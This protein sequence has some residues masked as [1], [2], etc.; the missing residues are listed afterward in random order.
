MVEFEESA[1][2]SSL[3]N[4]LNGRV[5]ESAECTLFGVDII[6]DTM[7]AFPSNKPKGRP[8]RKRR[9]LAP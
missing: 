7:P 6:K 2:R 4:L 8:S 1:E 5:E 3:G 9:A